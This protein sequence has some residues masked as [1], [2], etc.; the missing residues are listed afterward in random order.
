MCQALRELMKDEIQEKKQKAI[1]TSLIAVIILENEN[2]EQV[3]RN[4]N[5]YKGLTA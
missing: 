2:I 3:F 1:D 4:I 5:F